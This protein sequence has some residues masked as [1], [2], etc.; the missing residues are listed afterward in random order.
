MDKYNPE[1]FEVVDYSTTFEKDEGKYKK[2]VYD[3]FQYARKL[4]ERKLLA[5]PKN[6]AI[7]K[8]F[9][10]SGAWTGHYNANNTIQ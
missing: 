3:V 2:E 8:A 10:I 7:K 1:E 9:K 5:D 4:V 6:E